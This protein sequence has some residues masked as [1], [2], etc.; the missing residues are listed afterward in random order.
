M[1]EAGSNNISGI[2]ANETNPGVDKTLE[3]FFDANLGKK[4]QALEEEKSQSKADKFK[5]DLLD[6]NDED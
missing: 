1:S 5:I 2:E 6:F 4:G 3:D